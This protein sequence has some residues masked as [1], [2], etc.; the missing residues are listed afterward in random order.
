[1]NCLEFRRRSLVDPMSQDPELAEHAST[2]ARCASEARRL[3]G[4]EVAL[5]EALKV[6]PPE[7]L[8]A[9]VLQ[10]QSFKDARRTAT[11]RPRWLATAAALLVAVGMSI[12][13]GYRWDTYHGGPVGLETAVLDHVNSELNYLDADYDVQSDQLGQRFAQFGARIDDDIGHVSYAGRCY[14]RTR[15]GVHLVVPGQ[16]GAITVL[17]MPHERLT[18]PA[19]VHSDRFTGIIVP[20]NLGSVAVVGEKGEPVSDVAERM[21]HLVAWNG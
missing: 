10:A 18:A 5:R 20:T 7:G 1:M 17:F 3:V 11:L 14:I 9:R 13:L 4:F 12:W 6:S 15:P 21:Q 19:P 16:R 8:E 2:C